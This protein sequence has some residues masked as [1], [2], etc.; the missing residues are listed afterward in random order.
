MNEPKKDPSYYRSLPYSTE[1]LP[2]SEGGFVAHHPSLPGCAVE[3]DDVIGTLAALDEGRDLWIRAKLEAGE[4]IPEPAVGEPSG[5]L[6]LRVPIRLHQQLDGLARDYGK[7]LNR[8]TSELLLNSTNVLPPWFGL[9]EWTPSTEAADA[10]RHAYVYWLTPQ[11]E[12][13]Y[14]AEHPDLP[15]CAA[16]GDDPEE[17]MAELHEA[18]ELWLEARQEAGLEEEPEPLSAT[19]SG[20]IHLRMPPELHAELIREAKRNEISLN[21]MM[22]FLLADAVGELRTQHRER[23]RSGRA[24]WWDSPAVEEGI[25]SAV[26][27]LRRDPDLS[28]SNLPRVLPARAT[29]FLRAII[30][31]ERDRLAKA[32]E[33]LQDA[34]KERL[35]FGEEALG[36]FDKIPGPPSTRRLYQAAL[37]VAFDFSEPDP[38][39]TDGSDLA[40]DQQKFYRKVKGHLMEFVLGVR[41]NESRDVQKR[42]QTRRKRFAEL[43]EA[44]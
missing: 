25:G 27:V 7:S 34:V 40:D 21:Q 35:D 38:S 5:R 3:G 15:G 16:V 31:L 28:D 29:H 9:G 1:I 14:V 42:L 18:R 39:S 44:A 20:T 36:L 37:G 8:M 32:F 2:S 26:D 43:A 11:P 23:G 24:A 22:I 4:P 17:A 10:R 6:M 41:A 30:H 19:H 12:G 13:G 33:S